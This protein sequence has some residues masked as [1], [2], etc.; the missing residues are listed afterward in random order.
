V[1][2]DGDGV[3]DPW[4]AQKGLSKQ[5]DSKCKGSDKCPL[6]KEDVDKFEDTDGCP[7]P[8]N[9]K[10]GFCDPWVAKGGS[11]DKFKGA[12]AKGVDKCPDEPETVNGYQDDDGCPDEVAKVE[13]KK[14]LILDTIL[15][16]TGTDK[17]KPESEPIIEAV[18]QV[19]KQHPELKKVRIDGHTDSR[20]AA[21]KNLQ[22]SQKRANAVM[23]ALIAK[24]IG[25]T[26]LSAKGFGEEQLLV[27]PE[28]TE[29]D[30]QK[31][32][33]VEFTILEQ[34]E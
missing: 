27:K 4:V 20:D 22:L 16:F 2:N 7:D 31:N 29:A 10:D 3:C 19:L 1:D 25:P 6:E 24:G 26:R 33:R 5:Y 11:A 18:Y 28:K 14:I 30:Y 23:K 21:S 13:G 34:G 32:R 15:F 12:C 17:I 9:D 8:D